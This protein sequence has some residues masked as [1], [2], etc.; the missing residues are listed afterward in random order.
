[1]AV[2]A[3]SLFI[4]SCARGLGTAQNWPGIAASVDNKLVYLATGNHVYYIDLETGREVGRYPAEGDKR[5]FF[6]S[7]AL[8][9]DGSQLIVGDSFG[10]LYS[11]DALESKNTPNWTYPANIDTSSGSAGNGNEN[12]GGRYIAGD[13]VVDDKIFA[14]VS[15]GHL[16]ALD[17]EGSLLW[18]YNQFTNKKSELWASPA[19]GDDGALYLPSMDH[20][21]YAIN[22]QD[23]GLLW[24]SAESLGGAIAGTP[25]LSDSGELF[26]GTLGSQMV[27]VDAGNGGV[28]AGGLPANGWIWSGPVHN[29]GILHYGDMTGTFY[30]VDT[31]TGEPAWTFSVD[32]SQG[33]PG[34]LGI[35]GG[36]SPQP[37]IG[38]AGTPLVLEDSVYFVSEN[39]QLYALD[40]KNGTPLRGWPVEVGGTLYT[41]P[42]QAGEMILIA[43]VGADDL[44]SAYDLEGNKLWSFRPAE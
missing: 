5:N 33:D 12:A 24:K 2:I 43:Q 3:G 17:L 27:G 39:S 26:V 31:S 14:P 1:M 36:I 9:G 28:L 41:G 13:Q 4:S 25:A 37:K 34:S 44:L 16:Y 38:I 10:V 19:I 6:A 11:L 21:V 22:S 29:E 7:P 8:T 18:D 15:N 32:G 42:V 40:R 35:L 23:G 20:L 30:A